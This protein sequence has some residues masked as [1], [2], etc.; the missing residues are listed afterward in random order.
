M[1]DFATYLPDSTTLCVRMS[2]V[3]NQEDLMSV[4]E[5]MVELPDWKPSSHV[6]YDLRAGTQFVLDLN[7]LREQQAFVDAHRERLGFD[8]TSVLVSSHFLVRLLGALMQKWR[9]NEPAALHVVNTLGDAEEVLGFSSG[10][11][12]P[13]RAAEARLGQHGSR[14]DGAP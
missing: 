9:T 1:V 6:V 4:L 8:G 13:L 12:R 2:G 3:V 10:T 11:L 14:Y 7:D 5:L